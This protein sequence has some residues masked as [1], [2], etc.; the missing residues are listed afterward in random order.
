VTAL[1]PDVLQEIGFLTPKPVVYVANVP[2]EAAPRDSDDEEN[3]GEVPESSE[4]I[5]KVA[6]AHADTVLG[7]HRDYGVPAVVGCLRN[8]EGQSV[9]GAAVRV[10]LEIFLLAMLSVFLHFDYLPNHVLLSTLLVC[11]NSHNF[12]SMAPS[13]GPVWRLLL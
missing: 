10:G 12:C 2:T 13:F 3:L 7:L 5:S 6:L 9:L 4:A 8:P 11:I 1:C